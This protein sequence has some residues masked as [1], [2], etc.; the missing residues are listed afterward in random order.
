MKKL[1]QLATVGLCS[2]VLGTAVA[3]AQQP[4]LANRQKLQQSR[5]AQG[6]RSGELTRSEARR[7]ERDTS[8]IH[9]SIVNDRRD[10][11]VFT[12][13]ERARAQQRLNHQ[14]RAIFRQTHDIQG[15]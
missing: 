6:I 3:V 14:S 7:L 5:I 11:G 9:T 8:R 15:R 4:T 1:S 13:R 12:P 2:L 10:G